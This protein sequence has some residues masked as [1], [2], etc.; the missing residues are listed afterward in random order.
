MPVTEAEIRDS[1]LDVAVWVWKLLCLESDVTE[2][3]SPSR[4]TCSEIHEP[5]GET[6]PWRAVPVHPELVSPI[7]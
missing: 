4:R 7:H 3:R 5:G 6:H 1:L 2:V